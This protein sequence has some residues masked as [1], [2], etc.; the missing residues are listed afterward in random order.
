MKKHFYLLPLVAVL[1]AS[2]S[3]DDDSTPVTPVATTID[4]RY[5]VNLSSTEFQTDSIV[6]TYLQKDGTLASLKSTTGSWNSPAMTY[7]AGDSVY[8]R[9]YFYGKKLSTSAFGP[10]VYLVKTSN[11]GIV[12]GTGSS[13]RSG[14][15]NDPYNAV[16]TASGKVILQ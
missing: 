5:E 10:S 3:K 7:K 11:K 4:A 15:I 6:G 13:T 12:S 2:C 14:G 16:S 8:S 9:I 1:A